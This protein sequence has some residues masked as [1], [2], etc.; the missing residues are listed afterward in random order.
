MVEFASSNFGLDMDNTWADTDSH[1]RVTLT[2]QVPNYIHYP[3]EP[4]VP[5]EDLPDEFKRQREDY[6]RYSPY[7]PQLSLLPGAKE[8]IEGL[9]EI[10][11]VGRLY[12]NTARKV[13]QEYAIREL[14][15]IH[16]LSFDGLLLRGMEEDKLAGKLRHIVQNGIKYMIE[17]DGITTILCAEVLEG[18]VYLK[19][20]SWN[21]W[22]P[23]DPKI[24]RIHS[25]VDVPNALANRTP[26]EAFDRHA[27]G[28]QRDEE[29][30]SRLLSKYPLSAYLLRA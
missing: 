19:D 22:V 28:V 27:F 1:M 15:A 3:F 18:G 10:K 30:F 7:I 16:H 29:K 9:R 5:D 13:N 24:I 14:L 12:T 4:L 8:G 6:M 21:Q 26:E 25:V 23:R 20:H 11:H 2:A 17:D